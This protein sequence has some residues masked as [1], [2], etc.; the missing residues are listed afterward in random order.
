MHKDE[1][2]K[3]NY[4]QFLCSKNGFLVYKH[5]NNFQYLSSEWFK[6]KEPLYT[7]FD[8]D[9]ETYSILFNEKYGPEAL[10]HIKKEDLPAHL[11]LGKQEDNLCHEL[12]YNKTSIRL[13]TGIGGGSTYVYPCFFRSNT[14]TWVT[15]SSRK[16]RN[17]TNEEAIEIASETL[18]KLLLG[19]NL[20]QSV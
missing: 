16:N 18:D 14:Q 3:E 9:A 17:I 8:K 1:I 11:F 20:I 2:E 10:K 12:E 19:Y 13:F 4:I 6:S 15:G 7:S 5:T